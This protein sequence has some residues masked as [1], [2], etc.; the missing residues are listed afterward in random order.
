MFLFGVGD[1]E[2]MRLCLGRR[3]HFSEIVVL[4]YNIL[5]HIKT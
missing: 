4:H 2:M 5:L 1:D 3:G